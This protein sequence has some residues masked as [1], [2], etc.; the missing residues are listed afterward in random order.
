MSLTY[1][2]NE[3]NY[4]SQAAGQQFTQFTNPLSGNYIVIFMTS[5]WIRATTGYPVQFHITPTVL[6][7]T[8]YQWNITLYQN[9]LV[10]NVHFS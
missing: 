10:T 3:I 5:L 7:I 2:V 9:L 6:N 8:H 1:Y 4:T